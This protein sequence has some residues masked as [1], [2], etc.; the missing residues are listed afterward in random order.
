MHRLLPTLAIAASLFAAD[1]AEARPAERPR[2]AEARSHHRDHRAEQAREHR[3]AREARDHR[4]KR[5][6]RA[7]RHRR[8]ER[9][10]VVQ[11]P[12]PR[13][14]QTRVVRPAPQRTEVSVG[15]TATTPLVGVAIGIHNRNLDVAIKGGMDPFATAPNAGLGL[16][17]LP[18]LELTRAGSPVTVFGT[19]GVG[20]TGSMTLDQQVM[21]GTVGPVAGI[22]L[23]LRDLP[24]EWTVEARPSLVVTG[25]SET[26][27][28]VGLNPLSF[29]STLRLRF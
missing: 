19:L 25:N 12:A 22:G 8:P 5:R 17:V 15:V 13:T 16:D 21:T 27:T 26:G 6:H 9:V 20:A 4:K 11:Q 18:R 10:V 29:G 3:R 7:R 1:A 23:G 24:L 2:Q 14:R 28:E